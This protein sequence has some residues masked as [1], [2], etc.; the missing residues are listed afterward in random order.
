MQWHELRVVVPRGGVQA[1]GEVVFAHNSVGTQED[2]LP[3]EAPPPRQPWDDGPLPAAPKRLVVRAW[4]ETVQRQVIEEAL[5][6]RL[7]PVEIGWSLLDEE[8]WE[9]SWRDG[10]PRIILSGDLAIAPP[11]LAQ[12]GDVT[13]EPGQGFGTGQ[14]PT[15]RQILDHLAQRPEVPPTVLD[16]GCGSGILALVAARRGALARGFDTDEAAIADA[17]RQAAH[18]GLNVDFQVGTIRDAKP[19]ALVVANLYAELLCELATELCRV[20]EAELVLAGILASREVLV[21]EAFR[22]LSLEGRVQTGEW[23]CLRYRR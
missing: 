10:F 5:Q 4:F 18:N 9:A 7:G 3:G 8:D 17:R 20:T 12:P 2:Y 11:W 13:I 6:A 22:E 14:H 23:I 19:A 16:V 21:T 1:V 15:T